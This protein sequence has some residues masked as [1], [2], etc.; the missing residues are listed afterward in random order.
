M[1]EEDKGNKVIDF[2]FGNISEA[3]DFLMKGRPLSDFKFDVSQYLLYTRGDINSLVYQ[4]TLLDKE[5]GKNINLENLSFEVI[6]KYIDKQEF[7]EKICL[8]DELEAYAQKVKGCI[9]LHLHYRCQFILIMDYQQKEWFRPLL[10]YY[11]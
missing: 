6:T 1:I 10:F 8:E 3:L 9:Q 5:T 11:G 2:E 4:V 7:I